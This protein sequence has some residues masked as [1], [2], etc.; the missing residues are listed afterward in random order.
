MVKLV[1]VSQITVINAELNLLLGCSLRT[2]QAMII[3]V[4]WRA[5][6]CCCMP[7]RS[8][9]EGIWKNSCIWCYNW[10][11][12]WEKKT[13]GKS[14]HTWKKYAKQYIWECGSPKGKAYSFCS[15][16]WELLY[17]DDVTLFF[18]V[19][20]FSYLQTGSLE[21]NYYWV[22]SKGLSPL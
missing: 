20:W 9:S 7:E 14:T 13:V 1:P 19:F 8:S 10:R 2:R 6:A 17:T 18:R 21:K 11:V 16:E 22:S 4:L 12:L 5:P 15:Q 3:P